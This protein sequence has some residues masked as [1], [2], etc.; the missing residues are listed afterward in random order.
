[1]KILIALL[2]MCMCCVAFWAALIYA[3]HGIT[4]RVSYK[5]LEDK[6]RKQQLKK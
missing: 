4:G 3:I 1:M 6:K 2:L 5:E